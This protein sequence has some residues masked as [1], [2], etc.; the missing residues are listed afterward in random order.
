[1][2]VLHILAVLSS[3][4]LVIDVDVIELSI[5]PKTQSLRTFPFHVHIPNRD[6][7]KECEEVFVIDVISEIRNIQR[8]Q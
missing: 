6:K 1:M 8:E 4:D 3:S 2:T 7:P 5:E